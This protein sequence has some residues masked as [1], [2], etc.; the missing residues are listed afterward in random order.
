MNCRVCNANDVT[1]S[2]VFSGFPSAAQAF[3]KDKEAAKL[4]ASKE[5][6]LFECLTCGH[7]Q[8]D[9]KPVSY[10]KSVITAASLGAA[11]KARLEAEWK[12]ILARIK[13]PGIRALEIGAGTGDFVMLMRTWGLD[14]VGIE[15]HFDRKTAGSTEHVIDAYLPGYTPSVKYDLAVCNNFLEHHPKPRQLLNSIKSIITRDAYIYIS[16]PRFEY[17]IENSCFYE[18]IPDHLSYFTKDSLIYLSQSCG[19]NLIEYYV[20]NN[21]NDHV[22]ILQQNKAKTIHTQLKRFENIVS[23]LGKFIKQRASEGRTI[24]TWG[25]GHRALSLLSMAT[26]GEISYIVDSAPFK[27]G[28]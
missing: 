5:L 22:V 13:Q 3:Y 26:E 20:K 4:D 1:C 7:F 18:L 14:A 9:I 11:S 19:F 27:Q 28:L 12:P 24:A 17:I 10:Y 25:A 16:V 6:R 2:G 21:G 8:I 23:S 15:H